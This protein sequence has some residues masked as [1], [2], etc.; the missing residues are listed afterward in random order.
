MATKNDFE[1]GKE[2][3]KSGNLPLEQLKNEKLGRVLTAEEIR[4]VKWYVELVLG[5]RPHSKEYKNATN[6]LAR[7]GD[8]VYMLRDFND[9]AS[10]ENWIAEQRQDLARS[11]KQVE[12]NIKARNK[13]VIGDNLWQ[14]INGG[15]E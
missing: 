2:K 13:K 9:H 5:Y 3:V 1:N 4:A 6:S 10:D 11:G 7:E 14:R 12:D 15:R 8:P